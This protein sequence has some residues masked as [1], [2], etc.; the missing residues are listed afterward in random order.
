MEIP[1]SIDD[2]MRS[3]SQSRA[4]MRT[5]RVRDLVLNKTI[6]SE[7]HFRVVAK[8]LFLVPSLRDKIILK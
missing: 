1:N 2:L 4:K 6:C 7:I 3:R 5:G 8:A